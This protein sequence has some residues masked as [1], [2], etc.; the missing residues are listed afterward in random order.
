M[1]VRIKTILE[2]VQA[3]GLKHGVSIY[4]CRLFSRPGKTVKNIGF[5][6]SLKKVAM[7]PRSSDWGVLRQIFI[8]K[9]YKIYSPAHRDAIETIYQTMLS[10]G[11]VPVIIDCGANIGLASLWYAG[12]F[13]AAKIIAIEP[14]PENFAILQENAANTG[15]IVPIK[16]GVLDRKVNLSLRNK[17]GE[18][19]A[20]ET[21][22]TAGGEIETVT[23]PDVLA[24]IPKAKLLIVKIDIE[25][26]EAELFRSNTD[27]V[28]QAP[29]IVFESHDLFFSWRGTAHAVFRVLAQHPRDYL[30]VGENTFAFSHRH[31]GA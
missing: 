4:L 20:W 29:L 27:W 3:F 2:L 22:E 18:A 14:E 6:H 11:D 15:N 25:G 9:E 31:L 13:P 5:S 19:W 12:Q 23:I 8:E 21:R 26:S 30:Q 1:I 28:E 16:A 24:G 17:G 10:N 7:R